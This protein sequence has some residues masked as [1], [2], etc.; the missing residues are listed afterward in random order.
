MKQTHIVDAVGELPEELIAPVARLRTKKRHTWVAWAAL[1]AC[2]CVALHFGLSR[3]GWRLDMKSESLAE[4]P[5]ESPADTRPAPE[6][7]YGGLLDAEIFR[8]TVLEIHEGYILVKPL[9]GEWELTSA[10]KIEVSLEQVQP[11]PTLAVGDIVE[12]HYSGQIQETYP[13]RAA[14]VTAVNV[15]E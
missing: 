9:E 3:S 11:R 8:A 15:V 1:A 2:L 13:A 6:N 4:A 14:G 10:D 7:A 12:I 5:Q